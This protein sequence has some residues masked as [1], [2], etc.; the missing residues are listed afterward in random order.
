MIWSVHCL[1]FQK[2]IVWKKH[3]TRFA[4][5]GLVV[6]SCSS[7]L[8][9][10][11]LCTAHQLVL[12]TPTKFNKNLL[13]LFK[14][15]SSQVFPQNTKGVVSGYGYPICWIFYVPNRPNL[16]YFQY[17]PLWNMAFTMDYSMDSSRHSKNDKFPCVLLLALVGYRIIWVG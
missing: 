11:Q 3:F 12:L 14:K 10:W 8:E 5:K 16:V 4:T 9:V 7:A 17:K 6:N 13:L 2:Q 15:E 1:T